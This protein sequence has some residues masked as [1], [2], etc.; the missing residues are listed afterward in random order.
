MHISSIANTIYS[1]VDT[2]YIF[3]EQKLYNK[4]FSWKGLKI[5]CLMQMLKK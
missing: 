4:L 1:I 5:K 3:I 2:I